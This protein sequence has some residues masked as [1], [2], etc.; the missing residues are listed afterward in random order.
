LQMYKIVLYICLS[1]PM[2]GIVGQETR[3]LSPFLIDPATK[4]ADSNS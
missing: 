4:E 1:L 3:H 2:G